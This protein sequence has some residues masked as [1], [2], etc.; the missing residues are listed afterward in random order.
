M[1]RRTRQSFQNL[2][3]IHVPNSGKGKYKVSLPMQ[4]NH[5]PVRMLEQ[6]KIRNCSFSSPDK[7]GRRKEHTKSKL[8]FIE[9]TVQVP[10][11]GQRLV[12]SVP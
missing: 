5:D 4:C 6:V 8:L 2:K 1:V 3:Y 9:G 12:L 7:Q 11:T 10:V